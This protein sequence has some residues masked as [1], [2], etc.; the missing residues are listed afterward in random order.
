MSG[1]GFRGAMTVPIHFQP[2]YASTDLDSP[3]PR[4]VLCVDLLRWPMRY[5]CRDDWPRED[6]ERVAAVLE[7]AGDLWPARG[8]SGCQMCGEILDESERELP[9]DPL[10]NTMPLRWPIA[11]GHY[12]REHGLVIDPRLLLERFG[13]RPDGTRPAIL[14]TGHGA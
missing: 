5:H 11:L 12:V 8:E 7:S 1:A 4:L 14:P 13:V 3:S 6:R 9:G 2:L 10:A